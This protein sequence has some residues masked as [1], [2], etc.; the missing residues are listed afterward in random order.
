MV[1]EIKLTMTDADLLQ[2]DTILQTGSYS[3]P[4]RNM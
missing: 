3:M 1:Q 2:T 4:L